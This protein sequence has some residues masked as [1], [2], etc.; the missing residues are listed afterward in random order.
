MRRVARHIARVIVVGT[1][2]RRFADYAQ[3][4]AMTEELVRG[5]VRAA[6]ENAEESFEVSSARNPRSL[7]ACRV[8]RCHSAFLRLAVVVQ[9]LCACV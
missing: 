3:L 8:R 4:M 9:A 6:S 1:P 5:M 2:A 7:P